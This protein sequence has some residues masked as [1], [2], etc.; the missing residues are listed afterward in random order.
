MIC[1]KLLIPSFEE[2]G[3]PAYTANKIVQLFKTECTKI[4]PYR[5]WYKKPLDLEEPEFSRAGLHEIL[6]KYL[7]DTPISSSI[8][9]I[10]IP[11]AE[12]K[13]GKPWWFTKT[14]VITD[15]KFSKVNPEDAK[16]IKLIDIIEGSTAAPTYYGD[17]EIM[18]GNTDYHFMDGGTFSNNPTSMAVTYAESL[19]G[20]T[21]PKIVA[22]FGTGETISGIPG[23]HNCKGGLFYWG[24]NF[25]NATLNLT[26]DNV[27]N[28][29]RLKFPAT[30]KD[31]NLFIFQ[32]ELSEEDDSVSDTSEAH[33]TRLEDCAKKMII[34]QR[35]EIDNLCKKL[36]T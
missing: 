27:E 5:P 7:G 21:R 13:T 36:R 25:A 30:G 28:E 1:A 34:N 31:Q 16:N 11:A 9:E 24:R 20:T 26:S 2:D 23:A 10:L 22:C 32:P 35:D 14:K 6:K 15:P 4:F 33:M 3:T 29:M 8:K 17:K 18:I 19:F 12:M